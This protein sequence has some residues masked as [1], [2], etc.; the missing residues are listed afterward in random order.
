[1]DH[2]I[3]KCSSLGESALLTEAYARFLS[4]IKRKT[5]T[6]R[7]Y[8]FDRMSVIADT[9]VTH[10]VLM[11]KD[12]HGDEMPRIWEVTDYWGIGAFLHAEL[13]EGLRTGM[14]PKRCA[15]YGKYFLLTSG[16]NTDFCDRK[17][18]DEVS[19]TCRDIGARKSTTTK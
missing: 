2:Y 3:H 11:L 1:M 12:E 16:Y 4:D 6:K 7:V 14:L 8:V 19:K 10:E 18:P 15:N 5:E 13:F 17:A 9:L